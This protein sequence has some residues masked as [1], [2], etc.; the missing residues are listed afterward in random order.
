MPCNEVRPGTGS[1][2]VVPVVG[3]YSQ[4][5]RVIIPYLLDGRVMGISQILLPFRVQAWIEN[6]EQGPTSPPVIIAVR[7]TDFVLDGAGKITG[8]IGRRVLRG[9]GLGYIR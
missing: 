5:V 9:L 7:S 3:E 6:I 1:T 8:S 2:K 4:Q